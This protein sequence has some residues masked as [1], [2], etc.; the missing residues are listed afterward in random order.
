MDKVVVL[1][2]YLHIP[3]AQ[4]A[5]YVEAEAVRA[6]LLIAI[7]HQWENIEV[8]SDSAIMLQALTT[9]EEDLTEV[10]TIVHDCMPYM[11]AFN[12]VSVRHVFRE[13]NGV[14]YRLAHLASK[15]VVDEL[16][17]RHT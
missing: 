5:F 7:Y 12:F 3:Y 8:E 17:Q 6:G 15:S 13:A 9:E 4:S 11:Q 10:G 16:G 1:L 14:A 2:L